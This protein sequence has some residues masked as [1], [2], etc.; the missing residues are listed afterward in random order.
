MGLMASGLGVQWGA[1]PPAGDALE[2]AWVYVNV[3]LAWTWLV[4]WPGIRLSR[5]GGGRA[6]LG[7]DFAVLIAA[8]IP[9]LVIAAILSSASGRM[10]AGMAALQLSIGLLAMGA[11]AWRRRVREGVIATVLAVTGMVLPV[12]GFVWSEY[13]PVAPQ[14]W[15]GAIP[16]VAVT[17]AAAGSLS[18]WDA[19]IY[20]SL[21]IVL[22]ATAPRQRSQ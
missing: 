6:E 20:C 7:W 16:M 10:V 15:L 22:L 12:A 17:R 5:Q 19:L 14:A 11:M 4:I 18:G 9:A 8:A 13:F 21:G 2:L 3:A 1:A